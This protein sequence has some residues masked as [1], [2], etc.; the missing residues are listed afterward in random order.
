MVIIM[1]VIFCHCV[2]FINEV[3]IHTAG[4][5]YRFSQYM[6]TAN[7]AVAAP[8]L[9]VILTALGQWTACDSD[10]IN[11]LCSLYHL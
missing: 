5:V 3:S 6:H 1:R 9:P 8:C 4:R 7:A 2:S 10:T 11:N